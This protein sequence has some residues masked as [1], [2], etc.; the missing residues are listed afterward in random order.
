MGLFKFPIFYRA[1]SRSDLKIILLVKMRLFRTRIYHFNLLTPSN[2]KLQMNLH[3]D[4]GLNMI[5]YKNTTN[6]MYYMVV[7]VQNHS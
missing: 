7:R 4:V 2:E 1:K 5:H 3:K 6:Y